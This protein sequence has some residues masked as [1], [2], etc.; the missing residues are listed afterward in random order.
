MASYAGFRI[1]TSCWLTG[2]LPNKGCWST[3]CRTTMKSNWVFRTLCDGR[4]WRA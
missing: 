3:P 2:A 1:G 4:R